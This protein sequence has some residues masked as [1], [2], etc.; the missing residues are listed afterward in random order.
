MAQ[1]IGMSLLLL[2]GVL[3]AL[4]AS[5]SGRYTRAAAVGLVII[6]TAGA[7]LV[8]RD[9]LLRLR[10]GAIRGA[11]RFTRHPRGSSGAAPA[12]LRGVPRRPRATVAGACPSSHRRW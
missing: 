6:A 7:M 10:G 1:A 12:R 2:L 8:R 11:R 3:V 9:L 5:P 4:A